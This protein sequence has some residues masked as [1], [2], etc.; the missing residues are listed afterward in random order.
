MTNVN[1]ASFK[2]KIA[3]ITGGS[4]GIGRQTALTLARRGVRSIITYH[5]N[6]AEAET[7]LALSAE[8][9]IQSEALALDVGTAASFDAFTDEV[10]SA[11]ARMGA[12]RFDYLVNNAGTSSTASL[13]DGT[14]AELDAQFNVH[15]KGA[16]LLSQ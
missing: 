14:E 13:V 15:F 9:G 8:E 1:A 12:E 6:R 4:R 10:R 7:V 16:F 2:G 11:L 3:L 5:S